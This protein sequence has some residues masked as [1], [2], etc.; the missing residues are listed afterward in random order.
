[1]KTVTATLSLSGL[2][3]F[4]AVANPDKKAVKAPPLSVEQQ[5]A[6]RLTYP[7]ALRKTSENSVVV[8]QFRLDAYNRV[9]NLHV[10]SNDRSLNDELTRQLTNAKLTPTQPAGYVQAV[11]TARLRFVK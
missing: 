11:Y 1:M 2:I 4:G 10:F 9:T 8:V 5:L 3:A 7:D 6:G